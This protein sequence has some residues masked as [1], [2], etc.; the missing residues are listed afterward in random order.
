MMMHRRPRI[1][2][3]QHPLVKLMQ[4]D[5]FGIRLIHSLC[6]SPSLTN[7]I[8]EMKSYYITG[9]KE[10]MI[11]TQMVK[12]KR[13]NT[14]LKPNCFIHFD[15]AHNR[16]LSQTSKWQEM[17][18]MARSVCG[19][20]EPIGLEITTK[21]GAQVAHPGCHRIGQHFKLQKTQK[22]H[23]STQGSL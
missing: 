15:L 18:S 19:L 10:L 13:K 6:T 1:F 4:M 11:P 7:R 8:V 5:T 22:P 17:V 21:M 23:S 2:W 3:S 20:K 12:H 9:E 14:K 16:L